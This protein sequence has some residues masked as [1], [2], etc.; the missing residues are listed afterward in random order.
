MLCHLP[1]F[2]F[3]IIQWQAFRFLF[4]PVHF[5]SDSYYNDGRPRENNR[6]WVSKGGGI[7]RIK[8]TKQTVTDDLM[9]A[10][11]RNDLDEMLEDIFKEGDFDINHTDD[12]GDTALHYT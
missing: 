1:F 11:C 10:A 6:Q 3:P 7:T 9:L 4:I 8:T 5:F 12:L 2:W